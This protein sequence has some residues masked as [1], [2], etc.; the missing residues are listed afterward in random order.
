MTD[1]QTYNPSV[2]DVVSMVTDAVTSPESKRAYRRALVDFQQWFINAGWPALTK[3]AIQRYAAELYQNGMTPQNI[4]LRLSAI[5]R[6]AAE[7]GDNGLLDPTAAN[8]I[9]RVKGVRA[10][11]RKTG[12][13]LTREQAERLL[14]MPPADTRKGARDRALLAVLIGCGLRREEAARLTF[15]HIQQREARWVIIDLVGKRNKTRSVPMPAWCKAAIDRWA[16]AAGLTGGRIFYSVSRGDNL[17]EPLTA[18][19]VAA[20]CRE[21]SSRLGVPFSPHDLRR[22]FAKLARKGGAELT[23]IQLSLGHS[24]AAVTQRYIGEDQ[25]LAVAPCDLLGLNV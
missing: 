18:D 16:L 14:S 7:A 9:A 3:A 15:E 2:F 17:R 8:G 24:S 20:V 12:N 21:Y 10:E 1:L 6:L 4:N 5:R 13:W 23:Q 11:G 22:T 25:S 19:G